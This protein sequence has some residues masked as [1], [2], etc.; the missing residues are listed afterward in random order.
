MVDYKEYTDEQINKAENILS[1]HK[2]IENPLCTFYVTLGQST[3]S[4]NVRFVLY[5]WLHKCISPYVNP[6]QFVCVLCD[7]LIESCEK[8]IVVSGLNPIIID[9]NLQRLKQEKMIPNF[10]PFGKYK[11]KDIEDVLQSDPQYIYWLSNNYFGKNKGLLYRLNELKQTAKEKII[12]ENRNVSKSNFVGVE[13]Q[14]IIIKGTVQSIYPIDFGGYS[15]KIID[16]NGNFLT[17]NGILPNGIKKGDIITIDGKIKKHYE[18]MGTKHTSFGG[19]CK[20]IINN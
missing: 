19:R 13:G 5:K 20:I 8:S 15:I 9:F 6:F 7:D 1:D 10:I 3:N 12:Y 17:K 4:K 2:V 18:K 11:D 14:R 16:D